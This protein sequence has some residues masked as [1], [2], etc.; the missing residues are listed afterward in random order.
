MRKPWRQQFAAVRDVAK[1]LTVPM[2]IALYVVEEY[3][4]TKYY[5]GPLPLDA[6]SPP[7][8]PWWLL[9]LRNYGLLITLFISLLALPRWQ[10][11]LGL[12]GL[13]LFLRLY[14]QI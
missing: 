6:P 10:A 5:V 3:M 14:G 4:D 2:L 8:A 9:N 13:V 12:V 1:W 7:R 11:W